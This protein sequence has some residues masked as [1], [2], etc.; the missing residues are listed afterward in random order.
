M[1]FVGEV[2]TG[3][4]EEELWVFVREEGMVV[5]CR[6][7]RIRFEVDGFADTVLARLKEQRQLPKMLTSAQQTR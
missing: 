3:I 6:Y 7:R 4:F 1:S 2:W 5:A